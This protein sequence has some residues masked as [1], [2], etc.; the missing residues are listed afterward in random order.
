MYK[1]SLQDENQ[2][3]SKSASAIAAHYANRAIF[4]LHL[5]IINKAEEQEYVLAQEDALRPWV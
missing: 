4:R 1:K 3:I 5:A 2:A